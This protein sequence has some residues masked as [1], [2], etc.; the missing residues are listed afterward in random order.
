MCLPAIVATK[1]GGGGEGKIDVTD[2]VFI[3]AMIIN[4][5]VKMCFQHQPSAN[6][7]DCT[8]KNKIPLPFNSQQFEPRTASSI[9]GITGFT[10]WLS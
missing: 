5:K 6:P 1:T 7:K 3:K 4:F 2:L 8:M 9:I 10:I